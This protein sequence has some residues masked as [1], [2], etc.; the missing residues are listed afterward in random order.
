VVLLHAAPD[1]VNFNIKQAERYLALLQSQIAGASPPQQAIPMP[2]T[3]ALMPAAQ[4]V[5][6]AQQ[7]A[8]H[9]LQAM[10]A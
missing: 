9:T 3:P 5:P 4:A 10:Q 7:H 1:T 8:W 6:A 2:I